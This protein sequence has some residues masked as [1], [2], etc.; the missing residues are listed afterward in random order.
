MRCF[1]V[2]A[3]SP[4]KPVSPTGCGGAEQDDLSAHT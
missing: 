2:L 4:A 3:A 1:P